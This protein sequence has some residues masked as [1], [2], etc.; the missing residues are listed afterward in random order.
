MNKLSE[1]QNSLKQLIAI[2]KKIEFNQLTEWEELTSKEQQDI[3]FIVSELQNNI[4]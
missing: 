4:S 3:K 2:N 1:L